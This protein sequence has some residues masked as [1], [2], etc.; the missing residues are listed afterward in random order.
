MT[1]EQLKMACLHLAIENAS[2]FTERTEIM[3]LAKEMYEWVKA[4]PNNTPPGIAK[5]APLIR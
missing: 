3:A 2:S 4:P 1:D 5:V